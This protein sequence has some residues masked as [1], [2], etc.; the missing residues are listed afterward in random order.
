MELE[1]H[2]KGLITRT[3]G[4][5]IISKDHV[6]TWYIPG[7]SRCVRYTLYIPCIYL[8]Y[9]MYIQWTRYTLCIPC[10]Y[11][12]YPQKYIPT[13]YHVYTRYIVMQIYHVYNWYIPGISTAVS[14]QIFRQARGAG[15][16]QCAPVCGWSRG[17]YSTRQQG[18]QARGKGC[19]Q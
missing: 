6:Y 4:T 15:L 2:L 10:I 3:S 13:I 7:I 1:R 18:N 14:N 17:S 8:V 11:L 12:V 9:T 16:S 5:P 19:Q